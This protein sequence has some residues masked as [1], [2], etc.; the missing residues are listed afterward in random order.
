MN[1]KYRTPYRNSEFEIKSWYDKSKKFPK[2]IIKNTKYN[3]II[4]GQYG[5]NAQ[6]G[7]PELRNETFDAD[8]FSDKPH[9]TA[10]RHLAELNKRFGNAFTLEKG[11]SEGLWKIKLRWTK[12]NV[13]DIMKTPK[14]VKWVVIQGKRYRSLDDFKEHIEE[15]LK[16]PTSKFRHQKDVEAYKR[17]INYEKN[18]KNV[19]NKEFKNRPELVSKYGMNSDTDNDNKIN[20]K[21]CYPLDPSRQDIKSFFRSIF[22]PKTS[23]PK[24]SSSSSVGVRITPSGF[25]SYN[26]N[27]FTSGSS[28][29][30]S[31]GGSSYGGGSSGSSGGQSIGGG[32]YTGTPYDSVTGKA[33]VRSGSLSN[34]PQSLGGTQINIGS[35]L[36]NKNMSNAQKQ[37]AI[38]QQRMAVKNQER[39][40]NQESSNFK[41]IYTEIDK[42]IGGMLPYGSDRMTTDEI[43]QA[44]VNWDKK[45]QDK[46]S[47]WFEEEKKRKFAGES[48]NE[49][50]FTKKD[51]EKEVLDL[52]SMADTINQIDVN[53]KYGNKIDNNNEFIGT[54]EEYNQYTKDY[55]NQDK[56]I[57]EYQERANNLNE[58]GIKDSKF[59]Y[60]SKKYL[61]TIAEYVPI[62]IK[63]IG[64]GTIKGGINTGFY[65]GEKL[66]NKK[67]GDDDKL[68]QWTEFDRNVPIYLDKNVQ[69]LAMV[70]ALGGISGKVGKGIYAGFVG[71]SGYK[72]LNE[73]SSQSGGE[74]ATLIVLPKTIEKTI[75]LGNKIYTKTGKGFAEVNKFLDADKGGMI[76]ETPKRYINPREQLLKDYGLIGKEPDTLNNRRYVSPKELLL[77]N[78]GLLGKEPDVIKAKKYI[79]LK[80]QII[81]DYGLLGNKKEYSDKQVL[82]SLKKLKESRFYD[83]ANKNLANYKKDFPEKP[84]MSAI[85]K[86]D[87][88]KG[89]LESNE[90]ET[91]D[92]SKIDVS[93]L[94]DQIRRIKFGEDIVKV[95]I[96][97]DGSVSNEVIKAEDISN[98]KK[99]VDPYIDKLANYKKDFPDIAKK[100]N[101]EIKS[102]W[103]K[104]VDKSKE[105]S[106]PKNEEGY[107]EVKDSSGQVQL[108]KQELKQKNVQKQR[109]KQ[110]LKQIEKVDTKQVSREKQVLL[111]K[112]KQRL[113][114]RLLL[115]QK[116]AL[117]IAQKIAMAE[118]AGFKEVQ[119]ISF[120]Q[121]PNIKES[122]V[123][124]TKV[125]VPLKQELKPKKDKFGIYKLSSKRQRQAYLP[126]M[127]TNND[128]QIIGEPF[129]TY[130]EAVNEGE[131]NT[132]KEYPEKFV[133]KKGRVPE[134]K[135][136]KGRQSNSKYK[137]RRQGGVFIEKKKYT[138]DK[139][140][141]KNNNDWL[142]YLSTMKN[143]KRF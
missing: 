138:K 48:G 21:D 10:K 125:Y 114:I 23:T 118:K 90:L 135:I 69:T 58:S 103:E 18:F 13:A 60:Y 54:D 3:E 65:A 20:A 71:H 32:S 82:A 6:I 142:K 61:P 122:Q 112:E 140:K 110:E 12:Q 130:D 19:S 14:G 16:D 132:D 56:L 87:W 136:K 115:N 27:P 78:Y 70:G 85:Q 106:P 98:F 22:K 4:H 108:M 64:L 93:A 129:E 96:H 77:E 86:E 131:I 52:N 53:K 17:I 120:A 9:E 44:I 24:T 94:R 31:S 111:V 49:D 28:G 88:A 15:T 139:Y 127:L 55:K 26:T 102:K 29:N 119:D 66:T 105:Y 25:Q 97:K 30:S 116:S 34:V 109:I 62:T 95:V 83:D 74:L 126:V 137:F 80:E 81:K 89:K 143:Q 133:I 43:N 124:R 38:N 42:R 45:S 72:F 51:Y 121:L 37:N 40:R 141:E 68:K 39:N 73:P 41:K 50:G 91:T 76:G 36:A 104:S 101:T 11:K 75:K 1:K 5:I 92:W 67:L 79:N 107:A 35:I 123:E 47:D 7:V 8:V 57:N 100:E 2:T 84:D 33:I 46:L 117:A 128:E 113:N 99:Y 63:D 59:D 134:Y